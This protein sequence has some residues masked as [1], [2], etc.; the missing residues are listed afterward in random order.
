[1]LDEIYAVDWSGKR[2]RVKKSFGTAMKWFSG[3]SWA[4]V[5]TYGKLAFLIVLAMSDASLM[6]YLGQDP[7]ELPVTANDILSFDPSNIGLR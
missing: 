7:I 3:N 4:N 5:A 1:M 6:E 2:I